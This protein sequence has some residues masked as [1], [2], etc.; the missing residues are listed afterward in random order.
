MSHCP[1]TEVYYTNECPRGSKAENLVKFLNRLPNLKHLELRSIN[2]QGS[3]GNDY[4]RAQ[5]H[6]YMSDLYSFL[7]AAPS[8]EQLSLKYDYPTSFWQSSHIELRLGQLIR[9]H[10]VQLAETAMVGGPCS[11]RPANTAPVDIL[12]PRLQNLIVTHPTS[13]KTPEHP[14]NLETR[15]LDR[16]EE[17]RR[18]DFPELER[19]EV[20]CS[21]GF[22]DDVDAISEAY[23]QSAHIR[24]LKAAGVEVV[25]KEG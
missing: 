23:E 6:I 10:Q 19:I 14:V 15:L 11:R 9:L 18:S 20:E 1:L 21:K 25:V 7:E 4:Y 24:Q 22:G 2:G 12:P 16:L 17:L 8:I 13:T 5:G 3:T